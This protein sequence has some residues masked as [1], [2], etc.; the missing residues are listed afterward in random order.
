VKREAGSGGERGAYLVELY[1][2]AKAADEFDE[3]AARASA[4]ATALAGEGRAIRYLRSIFIPDDDTCFHLYVAA[5]LVE[6]SDAL[7]RAGLDHERVVKAVEVE[8][9]I[10]EPGLTATNLEA[11]PR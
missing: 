1:A 8:A 11:W 10:F 3:L 6:V 2:S 4:A 9:V 5:S 7:Q